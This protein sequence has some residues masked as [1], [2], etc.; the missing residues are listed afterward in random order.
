MTWINAPP[1]SK[2]QTSQLALL[3]KRRDRFRGR[4]DVSGLLEHSIAVQASHPLGLK[5]RRPG[6]TA[7][8]LIPLLR[9]STEPPLDH[10]ERRDSDLVPAIGIAVSVLISGLMWATLFGPSDEGQ[11]EATATQ[12]AT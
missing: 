5:R 10:E 11:Y 4:C 3:D 6:R 9:G 1:P 8:S 7:L 2:A 12:A